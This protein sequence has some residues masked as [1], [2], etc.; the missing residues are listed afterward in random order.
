MQ[1]EQMQTNGVHEAKAL[2]KPS[3]KRSKK[4]VADSYP[5]TS[6]ILPYEFNCVVKPETVS[7]R[8]RKTLPDGRTIEILKPIEVVDKEQIAATRGILVAV[9]P[10]AFTYER[11]PEGCRIPQPGDRVIFAKYAGMRVKGKDSKDDD[12]NDYYLVVKDKDIA[13][14]LEF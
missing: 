3:A 4:S 14:V 12:E 9:S 1:Q 6:G 5:N 10:V 7:D 8:I 2:R 13:A 11:W